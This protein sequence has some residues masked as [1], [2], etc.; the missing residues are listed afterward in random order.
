MRRSRNASAV[1]GL[2][3][4]PAGLRACRCT[5]TTLG[6]GGAFFLALILP[7]PVRGQ[8]QQPPTSWQEVQAGEVTLLSDL[9]HA[10]LGRLARRLVAARAGLRALSDVEFGPSFRGTVLLLREQRLA[11]AAG[12]LGLSVPDAA[13][14]AV[15]S[16]GPAPLVLVRGEPGPESERA[17]E[18]VL[19]ERALHQAAP[20]LP[21]W[22]V[23]GAVE[24]VT[25]LKATGETLAGA[26]AQP[27]QIRRLRAAGDLSLAA[28][29]GCERGGE[30]SWRADGETTCRARAW[31][32]VALLMSGAVG[33]SEQVDALLRDVGAGVPFERAAVRDL[34]LTRAQL[35]AALFAFVR[36]PS[37]ATFRL[38]VGACDPSP[39]RV[40]PAAE[41][42]TLLADSLAACPAVARDA[43]GVLLGEA[44]VEDPR[45]VAALLALAELERA[46][47]RWAEAGA[48]ID[49]ASRLAPDDPA[50]CSG[51]CWLLLGRAEGEETAARR[52]ALVEEAQARIRTC[53]A[54]DPTR[55]PLL[56]ALARSYVLA[57]E[58]DPSPGIDVLEKLLAEGKLDVSGASDLA[59][60]LARRGE[61]G[62]AEQV[63][64]GH[65]MPLDRAAAE[66]VS[67]AVAAEDRRRLE[68]LRG[69]V[70]ERVGL[71]AAVEEHARQVALLRAA[72][73]KA[74]RGDLRGAIADLDALLAVTQDPQ[75][76]EAAK[77]LCERFRRRLEKQ[78]GP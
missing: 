49:G 50:V 31:A 22:Y 2:I 62:R 71:G 45:H 53:L 35:E 32:L 66:V 59:R 46:E 18:R 27:D 60:L 61:R 40:V 16:C 15:E 3:Q 76:A 19:S 37:S 34:E 70:R 51:A 13:A 43:V 54:L 63:V 48:H 12:A 8:A 9:A 5:L 36:R 56:A 25:G 41:G 26:M 75:V 64:A 77:T 20:A 73:E 28:L 52:I 11:Q 14:I 69:S 10:N 33:R 6:C 72:E 58:E 38:E 24:L 4:P 55:K 17:I 30:A 57:P 7:A 42:L 23:A 74:E 47:G 78:R 29:D 65:V 67:A 21:R 39:P 1:S 68:R 44:L